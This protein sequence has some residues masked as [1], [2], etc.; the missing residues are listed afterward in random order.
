MSVA[1]S[2]RSDEHPMG[3]SPGEF[4]RGALL[5]WVWFLALSTLFFLPIFFIYFVYALLYT[6]PFSLAALVVGALPAYGLGIA[7]RAVT[8]VP[9]H[10]AAFAVFGLLVGVATT[11]VAIA[12]MG[13][14]GQGWGYGSLSAPA[15]ATTL[16]ATIAVPLGWW[17]SARRALRG[18]RSS[19]SEPTHSGPDELVEDAID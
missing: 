3:F 5:A 8:R 17:Q 6:V 15:L 18:D 14:D 19:V 12:T 11:A 16:A 7:L 1:A 4:L 10:L 2:P 9:V 13:L